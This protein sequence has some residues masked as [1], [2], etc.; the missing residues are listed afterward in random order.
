MPGKA[1]PRGMRNLGILSVGSIG[2]GR[3]SPICI[4][5]QSVAREPKTEDVNI[6]DLQFLLPE[7]GCSI[8]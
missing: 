4:P 1:Q 5:F 3:R 8:A 2:I 6:Y 7:T